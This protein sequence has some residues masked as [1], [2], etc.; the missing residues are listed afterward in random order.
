LVT[1]GKNGFL[2]RPADPD[3]LCVAIKK[4]LN[5]KKM[6]DE[7]GRQGRAVAQDFSVEKMIE[8]IDTLYRSVSP[9]AS[10]EAQSSQRR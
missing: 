9:P 3:D 8:K 2:V 5:D 7:M 10:L 4:L 6:R 1:D